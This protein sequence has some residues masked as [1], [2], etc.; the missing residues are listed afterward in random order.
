M[1]N[2]AVDPPPL[3]VFE[4]AS[5]Q[6]MRT[7]CK[8]LI[9]HLKRIAN[10]PALIKA[11]KQTMQNT[12][13]EIK[14]TLRAHPLNEDLVHIIKKT[15]R[16]ILPLGAHAIDNGVQ[17]AVFSQYA[18]RVW[19]MIFDTPNA[20]T[21]HREY[22]LTPEKNRTGYI[23]HIHISPAKLGHYYLY[24]MDGPTPSFN[25][26]QW[27]L[28][29]YTLSISGASTWGDPF[30]L[31]PGQ[32]PLQGS[33]FPKNTI[34]E[35]TF[36]WE[37][38]QRPNIP[39]EKMIIYETHLRGYTIDPSANVEHPGTYKGFIE[40]IPYLKN[41]GVTTIELL[42]IQEFNEM[43][44]YLE[45]TNR[46]P[47]LNFW[48]YSTLAF[49]APNGRYAAVYGQ[50]IQECKALIKALHQAGLEVILDVVFNHTAEGG[51]KGP[52]SSFRGIDDG[53]YYLKKIMGKNIGTTLDAEI[54]L[55]VTTRLF[56]I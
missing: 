40:K 29:P 14:E 36:N 55:T 15:S 34:I 48:G 6:E 38:V 42:P 12:I 35:N 16:R 17:L 10:S 49:F 54:L 22:E 32:H 19:L 11:Q 13:Q 51:H 24:R 33:V 1:K 4:T 7:Y 47:L 52:T 26:K 44:F 56:V 45:H 41:L 39:F 27:L 3:P 31:Q 23:W 46:T 50:Q 43:E 25:P 21:P 18:T 5:H 30:N 28:D 53:V 9:Q 37:N 2:K 8:K 20:V